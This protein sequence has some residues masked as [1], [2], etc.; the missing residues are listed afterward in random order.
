MITSTEA[1]ETAKQIRAELGL[2]L[3][4]RLEPSRLLQYLEIPVLPLSALTKIKPDPAL[5]AAV[6]YLLVEDT[7]ALSAATVFLGRERLIVHN[8]GHA[9]D[10]I[11]SNLSHEAAHALLLHE[12]RPSLDAS[13]CRDWHDDVEKEA[14]YLAGCLLIPGPAARTASRKGLTDSD[15]AD[16]YGVSDWM[17]RY[18]LNMTGA[19]RQ[20]RAG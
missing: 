10:R 3:Y 20:R 13:G 5:A 14:A 15:V 2:N 19:R 16:H 8:D 18:R 4:A 1:E 7:S 17:A 12:P 9:P 11:A 6:R